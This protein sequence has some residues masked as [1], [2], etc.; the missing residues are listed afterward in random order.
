MG[1]TPSLSELFWG[2]AKAGI[3][4]FG[5]AMQLV[6]H[7]A[8]EEKQWIS[9]SRYSEILGVCQFVPGPNAT[10]VSMCIGSELL[11]WK[12]GIAAAAG[13]LSGPA[14]FVCLLAFLFD[15]FGDLELVQAATKGMGAA[16]AGILIAMA[17]KQAMNLKD[18]AI[19][20]PF[21]G[22][23]ALAVAGLEVPAIAVLSI[24]LAIGFR[25]ALYRQGGDK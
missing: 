18:K 23:I 22:S 24:A 9:K 17:T 1:K 8:V 12:G 21:A 4:S 16:G 20:L 6:H 25:V 14:I 10:N 11:G 15:S 19:W 7:V 5:G 3:Q 13:L 2:F